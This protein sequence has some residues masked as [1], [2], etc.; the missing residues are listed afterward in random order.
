MAQTIKIKRSGTSG[1]K[2]TGSNSV[3]GEIGM[4]TADK[5]L[6]IQTGSNN[7]DVVTVAHESTLKIDEG[8]NRVG[9]GTTSPGVELEV[10]GAN[11]ILR[12]RENDQT[13]RFGD[14]LVNSTRIRI[15]SRAGS[16]NG[17][18]AFEG[19][20]GST[21]TEYARFNPNGYLGIGETDPSAPLH[22]GG[23]GRV[24]I[25]GDDS[26]DDKYIELREGGTTGFRM[27]LRT[28]LVDS[29]GCILLQT[30]DDKGFGIAVN[31]TAAWGSVATSSIPFYVAEGGSVGIGTTAPSYHLHVDA[32]TNNSTALFEADGVA[33]VVVSGGNNRGS[34]VVQHSGTT[35]GALIAKSGGGLEFGVGANYATN[36]RMVLDSN[37]AVTFNDAFT[38]PTAIGSAGQVLKV[39]TSG[40]TLYWADEAAASTGTSIADADGDTKIQ[41]EESADE[42][43][44]RF[45]TAGTERVII[46]DTGKVGIGTSFPEGIMHFSASSDYDI[47]FDNTS[48]EKF[49]LRHGTSGIYLTGP[50]TDTLAF[51][52]D[53]SHDVKMFSTSGSAYATFDG[54]TSRVGIG[55][56]TPSYPFDVHVGD[57]NTVNFTS[58]DN[59]M[60]IRIKDNDTTGYVGV[61]NSTFY[62]GL[63]AGI[64]TNNLSIKSDGGVGIGTFAP[65]R[66]LHISGSGVTVAAKVEA[67]DGSQSS[68]DLKNSE[69]EFRIINDGGELSI[70]DQ[71][72]TTERLRIDTAGFVGIGTNN[73]FYQLDV[74]TTTGTG[75]RVKDDNGWATIRV[76]GGGDTDNVLELA[77]YGSAGSGSLIR[78]T[79]T[80]HLR[81]FAGNTEAIRIDGTT[82]NVGVGETTPNAALHVTTGTDADGIIIQRN[83]TT[84]GTSAQLGFMPS[85]NSSGTP[86][87][88]IKGIRGA[89]SY[90]DN[91]MTFGTNSLERMRINAVGNIGIGTTSPSQKLQVAG[92]IL[93]DTALAASSGTNAIGIGPESAI[94]DTSST[95]RIKLLSN[96]N[97]G[98]LTTYAYGSY[99]TLKAG[100]DGTNYANNWSKIELRDGG[101]VGSNNAHM[102]FY[103]H[104]DERM[105]IDNDGNVGIGSTDPQNILDLGVGTHGRGIAWGG[106]NGTAH[107]NTIW[108]E[109]SSASIII[110]AGL[111]G[112]TGSSTFLNPFTGT[113]GYAAI[114]L[115]SFSDD[116]IK[117]YTGADSARTKDA[118][119]TPTEQMRLTNAGRLG[120]GTTSPVQKLDVQ[121][122]FI[123]VQSPDVGGVA[124]PVITIGQ[125]TN[126]YQAGMSS[127]V[128][129]SM[130][131]TN[132]VGNFYWYLNSNTPTMTLLNTGNLGLG[133]TSPASE[134]E[135]KAATPVVTVHATTLTGTTLGDKGPKLLFKADSSTAGNGGEIVFAGAGDTN[136]ERWAAISGH[137]SSNT[138]D[139]C[140]GHLVF[141][142]KETSTGTSLSERMRI[143]NSGNIGIGTTSPSQKLQVEGNIKLDNGSHITWSDTNG[144]GWSCKN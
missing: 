134:L 126:A 125:M 51:G 75:L 55:T 69:G 107:Y 70:Y 101:G 140:A 90:N 22:I 82:Q 115:D 18:I 31:T 64:G 95:Y 27:G 62:L 96:S 41:V 112:A 106:S 139:G 84:G 32:G 58:T 20:N 123:R 119:I 26:F 28:N 99:L 135:V 67:T 30:G 21:T 92:T 3:A 133:T 68:I 137:I 53:Q 124:P 65:N 17:S 47:V 87:L 122:G 93:A 5:A 72:D 94:T 43:K 141:A 129:L 59:R 38:F 114:E 23:D 97:D 49:K 16:N 138:V 1:N 13:N 15:R 136:V 86:N 143:T 116:G 89:G 10:A 132:N 73:P 54:S 11:P 44:I 105:V 36:V 80:G 4:N 48:E 50:D 7:S 39:P 66:Q 88:W 83:S 127:N 113:Y 61:E 71:T 63:N 100:V 24:A 144:G 57:G 33:N 46:D 29:S 37:G 78:T 121:D 111:K 8:N 128:H 52:V 77:N 131:T 130:K 12:I 19:N 74:H 120:I 110:G 79:G 76:E 98:K 25:F 103:T 81:L 40:T 34:F 60:Q 109:Y 108:S 14:I 104:G 102:K 45:D 9:I 35:S 118:A 42:D 56:T 2:L 91:Y 6:Y 142:T 85:T 117:F